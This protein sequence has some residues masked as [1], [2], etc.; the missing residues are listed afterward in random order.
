MMYAGWYNGWQANY[1]LLKQKL[2]DLQSGEG[3]SRSA[4]LSWA[5]MIMG[6]GLFGTLI[7]GFGNKYR[8]Q[9][10]RHKL[11]YANLPHAFKGLKIVHISD[12][13]SGSFTDKAAV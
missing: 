8:Y 7:Y 6:G 13:H 11:N 3:I 5:G 10:K 2:R 4:F 9:V 1:F 12:V